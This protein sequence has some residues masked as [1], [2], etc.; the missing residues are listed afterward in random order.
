MPIQSSIPIIGYYQFFIHYFF[1]ISLPYL[2]NS[3]D[4][5]EIQ[6]N[7]MISKK[8]VSDKYLYRRNNSLWDN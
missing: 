7:F 6:G 5:F 3:E 8:P 2:Q 1:F 4:M